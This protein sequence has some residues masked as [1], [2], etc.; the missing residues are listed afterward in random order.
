MSLPSTPPGSAYAVIQM[1]PVAVVSHLDARA[2]EEAQELRPKKYLILTSFVCSLRPHL[3]KHSAYV[4]MLV[5]HL[6]FIP[7]LPLVGLRRTTCWA[8]ASCDRRE[9][10]SRARHVRSDLSQRGTPNRSR[11]RSSDIA[12][13]VRQLLPLSKYEDGLADT[14]EGGRVR[15]HSGDPAGG[16][17]HGRHDFAVQLGSR[18]REACTIGPAASGVH[19]F[20]RFFRTRVCAVIHRRTAEGHHCLW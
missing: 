3:Y 7:R 13:P 17:R 6:F 12:V 4:P 20:R 16:E 18:S 10:G 8:F 11:P 15:H 14:R 1:D 5:G 19:R 2:L 9:A